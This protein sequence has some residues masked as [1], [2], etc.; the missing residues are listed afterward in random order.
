MKG[1]A[2]TGNVLFSFGV[3]LAQAKLRITPC[4]MSD[5]KILGL[6][7]HHYGAVTIEENL[8]SVRVGTE[9]FGK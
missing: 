1:V 5:E 9:V 7:C 6:Y 8:N 2:R 3:I 4:Y